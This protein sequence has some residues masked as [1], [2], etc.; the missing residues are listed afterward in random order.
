M[1]TRVLTLDRKHAKEIMNSI[2]TVQSPTDYKLIS[3]KIS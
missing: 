2:G 3:M 1:N